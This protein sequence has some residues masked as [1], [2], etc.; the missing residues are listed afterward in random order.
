MRKKSESKKKKLLCLIVLIY[1]ISSAEAVG[2][3]DGETEPT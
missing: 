3:K 1:C 2:G